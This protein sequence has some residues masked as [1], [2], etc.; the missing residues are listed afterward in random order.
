MNNDEKKKITVKDIFTNKQYKA[1][2][3][4]IFYGCVILALIVFIRTTPTQTQ[5]INNNNNSDTI[6]ETSVPGF[7]S[8]KHKNF[9][10][11]YILEDGEN[12]TVYEGKQSNNAISFLETSES[13]PEKKEFFYE[14]GL[15][16]EKENEKYVLSKF[17]INYFNFFDVDLLEKIISN[18]EIDEDEYIISVEKFGKIIGD[19]SLT[20]PDKEISI[21]MEKKNNTITKIEL[22]LSE[23]SADL[24]SIFL[25]LE[26]SNFNLIDDFSLKNS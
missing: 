7:Q 20:D 12:K 19:T 22:D 9:N 2:A 6:V 3:S 15:F 4:L 11:K 21:S 5:T 1:I 13:L 23:L 18:S 26:Y 16:F 24:T 10:F 25:D 14:D 17:K 8:I